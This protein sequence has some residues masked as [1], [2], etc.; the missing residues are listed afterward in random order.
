MGMAGDWYPGSA[1]A[2]AAEVDRLLSEAP[3]PP[4]L[5]GPLIA[6]VLPHAGWRFSGRI[7][8]TGVK[9]AR[10]QGIETVVLLGVCHAGAKIGLRGAAIHAEGSI[11]TPLGYAEVDREL[12]GEIVRWL[13][14]AGPRPEAF[15]GEHSV[16]VIVPFL[17]RALGPSVRVV[18]MLVRT[19]SQEETHAVAAA[20]EMAVNGFPRRVLLVASTDLA[21]G[22]P[23]GPSEVSDAETVASWGTLDPRVI[24][25]KQSEIRARTPDLL[26]TM[27]GNDPVL[28]TL[29][30][31][32]LLG[33]TRV[34][35][36]ERGTSADAPA[37][38]PDRVVGYAA[39]AVTG[40]GLD[41]EAQRE[42]LH[43]AR[44]TVLASVLGEPRP[45]ADLASLPAVLSGKGPGVFVTL[46]QGDRVRACV[47]VL[48]S[49]R[50][51]ARLV[52]AQ[53][54]SAAT[55]DHR[56]VEEPLAKADLR[57]VGGVKIEISVLGPIEPVRSPDEIIAGVHGVSLDRGDSHAVLLPQVA[58]E[59]RY[60]REKFLASLC[61]KAKIPDEAWKD[62]GTRLRKFTAF[63]FSE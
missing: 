8:A 31:A 50:P 47:G 51:L 25:W 59:S 29:W 38:S 40:G 36:L 52:A 57:P 49:E 34:T 41:P 1:A 17:Q 27:C 3:D 62:P 23:K 35:V 56:I 37:G 4:P 46:R 15:A 19:E 53:A 58:M 45:E 63:V 33:G 54:A 28:A 26:C 24:H 61:R 12:A 39:A 10:G 22:A 20:L 6:L 9:A 5:P 11:E 44:E 2:C 60:S 18:P 16:E 7:C 43:L 13:P 42:L 21:H 32:R 55:K 30:A 48:A 14:G